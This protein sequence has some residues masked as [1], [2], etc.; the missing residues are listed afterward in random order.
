[1]P[2]PEAKPMAGRSHAVVP[3]SGTEA[4]QKILSDETKYSLARLAKRVDN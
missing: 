1:L 4:C 2:S 3:L